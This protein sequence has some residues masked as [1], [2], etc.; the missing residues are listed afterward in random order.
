ML[1]EYKSKKLRTQ[2]ENPKEA[3]KAFGKEIG[4]MITQ[5]V[6]EIISATSLKDIQLIPSARLHKLK[7][8]RANQFGIDLAGPFRL[9]IIPIINNDSD[10]CRL[11]TIKIVRIEEV[12]NYHGKQKKR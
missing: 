3:Q 2:C 12:R 9:V 11:E 10:I 4:N 1:I 8:L 5:R 7:G 6:G